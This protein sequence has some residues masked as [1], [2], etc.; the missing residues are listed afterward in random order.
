[1][2]HL[3]TSNKSSLESFLLRHITVCVNNENIDH[4]K[5]IYFDSMITIYRPNMLPIQTDA[6]FVNYQKE[7]MRICLSQSVTN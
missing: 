4:E 3:A 2:K 6:D 5:K 1:M 7:K